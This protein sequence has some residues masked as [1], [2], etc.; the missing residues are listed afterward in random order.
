[1]SEWPNNEY[2]MGKLNIEWDGVNMVTPNEV[3]GPVKRIEDQIYAMELLA[4]KL[5]NVREY[6]MAKG[7]YGELPP[8]REALG[9][10]ASLLLKLAADRRELVGFAKG[11]VGVNG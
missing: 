7:T 9:D 11:K 4:F 8:S 5:M 10:A 6:H 3:P 1:M 2:L